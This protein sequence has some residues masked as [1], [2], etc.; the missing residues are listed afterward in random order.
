M[1]R[2]QSNN[3]ASMGVIG[4]RCDSSTGM[5]EQWGAGPSMGTDSIQ[6][7]NFSRP[8]IT[9]YGI[10]ISERNSSVDSNRGGSP[11]VRSI[12]NSGFTATNNDHPIGGTYWV[13]KGRGDC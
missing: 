2:N 5:L 3:S 1:W 8:F 7:I 10:T 9:V 4:W 13:A 12:T 11:S 6:A